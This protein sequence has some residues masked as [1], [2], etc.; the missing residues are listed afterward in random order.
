MC[1]F[2]GFVGKTPFPGAEAVLEK[3][4]SAIAHRGPD[5]AGIWLDGNLSV[6]L[7]HRRLSIMDLSELGAQPMASESGRYVIAFNGEIYNFRQLSKELE[8]D[9]AQFRGHS[10][11]EV[12][13]AA[14]EAWG[15]N[16]P[17]SDF[18]G[19]SPLR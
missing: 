1:G 16:R 4:G 5:A 3:M 14:F 17:S 9:G 7:T 18:Q 15:S 12:M 10:D 8:A 2:A 13:L 11:T 19:C 6:G